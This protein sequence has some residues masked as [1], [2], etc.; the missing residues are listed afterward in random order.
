MSVRRSELKVGNTIAPDGFPVGKITTKE[1]CSLESLVDGKKKHWPCW[2]VHTTAARP[3]H[4]YLVVDWGRD[5]LF[6]WKKTK[7]KVPPKNAQLWLERSGLEEM[8]NVTGD[9]PDSYIYSMCV[10]KLDSKASKL[11]GIERLRNDRVFRYEG[12]R[13]DV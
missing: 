6:L 7:L 10:F 12:V 2:T 9:G 5:G 3:F 8:E 1:M 4:K 11:L 13:I